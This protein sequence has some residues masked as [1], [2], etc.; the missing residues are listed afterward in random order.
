M[1]PN[2]TMIGMPSSGKSTVGVLLAK[3]LGFSFVDVDIVIQEKE[4]R[5]LKEI[6]AQE[7]MD[8]FL[9]VE[10]RIN[11]GLDVKLSVIAPG[12]SVI[13]GEEAMRHLKEISEVVYLKMSYEEME[14]RIGNVVDRGVALKPGFTLRDLYNERVPYY[15]KYADI[16]I[17][18]AGKTPGQTVDE[19][20]DIIESMMDKKTI[21]TLVD[22]QK[23]RLEEKDRKIQAY[24]KEI[25]ELKA[26]LSA[27]E[28]QTSADKEK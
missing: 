22:E 9:D 2:I 15:E 8:G 18:E 14:K 19:L 1:K 17:D 21:Q 4:G 25:E 28:K 12:G 26:R 20:R 10:N 11:A 23:R 5:L 27:Y 6:I 13:Y 24:E 7:G 16:V 3:R